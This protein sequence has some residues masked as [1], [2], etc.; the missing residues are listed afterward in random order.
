MNIFNFLFRDGLGG[1]D[2]RKLNFF[3]KISVPHKYIL[4]FRN[5]Y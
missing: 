2:L 1:T 5:C 4:V 3:I